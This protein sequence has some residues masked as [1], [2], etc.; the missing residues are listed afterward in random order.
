MVTGLFGN[1]LSGENVNTVADIFRQQRSET[2][3]AT[4]LRNDIKRLLHKGLDMKFI[5]D[6]IS[7]GN[8]GALHELAM[9]PAAQVR[10]FERGQERLE[11]VERRT[12]GIL[13]RH[14]RERVQ[15]LRREREKDRKAFEDAVERG[16]R[17]GVKDGMSGRSS[18]NLVRQGG[19]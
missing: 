7:T 15:D 18:H 2:G 3:S 5:T 8:L 6:L 9:A 16:A 10:R 1:P 11:R 19:G 12:S 13:N 4:R 14:D 17:K